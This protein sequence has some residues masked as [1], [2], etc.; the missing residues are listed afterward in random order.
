VITR[1]LA[2]GAAVL[3]G[4]V[5]F[6][7]VRPLPVLE[8]L[9]P[10]GSFGDDGPLL[11]MVVLGDSTCT[12]PGLTDPDETWPRLLARRL[13][14]RRRVELTSLAVGGARSE[15]VLAQ[16]VPAALALAP[17]LAIVSVGSND[18]LHLVPVPRFERR[19]DE[20]VT[21]L[22]AVIPAV[23]LFGIGDLGSIPRIPFPLDRLAS[24]SGR[25]ADGVHI[26]VAARH[27]VAK[28][29]QWALTTAA[30]RNG[31]HMFAA[32]LFHPSAAGH[33]A[34]MQALAPTIEQILA[35]DPR[36]QAGSTASAGGVRPRRS[37]TPQ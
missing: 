16:Q 24:A 29:D 23:V 15:D 25:V 10:S 35:G 17:D 4:Q 33:L 8:D 2:T 7:R 3:A 32:D 5:A 9:D 34:W 11:R 27:G 28:V 26:R 6:A 19:L 12:G 21:L 36:G 22:T 37:A 30:F 18:I 14:A 1:V 20:I 31:R 13:A